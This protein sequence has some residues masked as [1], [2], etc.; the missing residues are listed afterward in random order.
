M[1]TRIVNVN[2]LKMSLTIVTVSCHSNLH[3]SFS[4]ASKRR[5]NEKAENER[6]ERGHIVQL[7]W[8]CS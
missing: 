3:N 4:V 8:D 6:E 1:V 7:V 5:G 2:D